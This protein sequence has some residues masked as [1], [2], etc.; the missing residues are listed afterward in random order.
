MD[1][2]SIPNLIELSTDFWYSLVAH[3]IF[4]KGVISKFVITS[5]LRP[6]K[7]TRGKLEMFLRGFLAVIS[8][9]GFNENAL[10]CKNT[11]KKDFAVNNPLA[12]LKNSDWLFNL[13]IIILK[14]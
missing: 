14:K 12:K 5:L 13:F 11:K 9:T 6:Q 2:G 8:M 4:N 7:C 10:D 3:D 1:S